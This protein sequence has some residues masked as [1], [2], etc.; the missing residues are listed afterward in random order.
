LITE[1][2]Y[3]AAVKNIQKK[4]G[5]DIQQIRDKQNTDEVTAL[6]NLEA[7][8][9]KTSVGFEAAWHKNGAQAAQDIQNM[10]KMGDMSFN[11]LDKSAVAA[12]QSIGNGSQNA[13]QALQSAMFGA[14]GSI[15]TQMGEYLILAGIGTYDPIQ[16]AE[17]GLLVALGSAL[18]SMG[19]GSQS[20]PS[21]S[22]GGGG[23]ALTASTGST[24]GSASQAPTPQAQQQK[25]LTVAINGNIFETDQT[26]TRLMDMIRQSQD[27]TDFSLKNIGTA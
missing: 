6:K 15:A 8:N 22:G 18:S 21:S 2:Q 27:M 25:S 7:Q 20:A 24:A 17:G 13:A 1:E 19:S 9:L 5:S 4:L 10:G 23:G 16:I 26:R 11:A 14:I 12:F 3:A